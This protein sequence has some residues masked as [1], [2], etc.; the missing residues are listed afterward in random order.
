MIEE[1]IIGDIPSLKIKQLAQRRLLEKKINKLERDSAADMKEKEI[2]RDAV[3]LESRR[4]DNSVLG[5]SMGDT[6][7]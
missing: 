4:M 5:S 7:S 1:A 2:R 3:T 6:G